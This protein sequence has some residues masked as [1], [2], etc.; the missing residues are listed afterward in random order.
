MDRKNNIGMKT[1]QKVK[2]TLK[3]LKHKD[4]ERFRVITSLYIYLSGSRE[5]K[6]KRGLAPPHNYLMEN[7]LFLV[8]D[9]DT[10]FESSDTS[11]CLSASETNLA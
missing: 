1:A 10:N 6:K 4:K 5:E 7:R 8:N 2:S 3:N 11:T 9:R